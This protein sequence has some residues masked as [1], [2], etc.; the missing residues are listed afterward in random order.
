MHWI[1]PAVDGD[2]GP[3][4][5][6]DV[7]RDPRLVG[8]LAYEFEDWSGD[9]VV[10]CAGYWLVTDSL[11]IALHEAALTGCE[12]GPVHVTT[13]EV[14]DDLHPDGLD[15]P[16]WRRFIPGGGPGDDFTV[17][18]RVFLL[19]SDRALEVL[20]RFSI[21]HAEVREPAEIPPAP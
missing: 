14:F 9:D 20:Q 3:G 18:D 4:V 5:D 1:R 12:T 17:V 15:M 19:V 7:T 10:A 2:L 16:T 21:Q 13:S 11:A 6:Y 8:D